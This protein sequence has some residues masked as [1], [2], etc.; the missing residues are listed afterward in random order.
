VRDSQIQ[1]N[2]MSFMRKWQTK[3]SVTVCA[4]MLACSA[5]IVGAEG[6]VPVEG[7]WVATTS[8]GLPVSFEVREGNV[9]NAHFRFNWGFCGTYES[10]L[11]NTDP[12]DSDGHWSF[13]DS[14]GQTIEGTFVTPDRV[15]GTV[16]AAERELPGCPHTRATF[17]AAPGDVP[18]Y[19]KPQVL[20]VQNVNTGHL[21]RR[22][23]EIVLGKHG[24]FSFRGLKWRSFGARRAYAVGRAAI[25]RGKREW[26]PRASLRLSFL[27]EDGPDKRIY[28][29]IRYALHG[30]LPRGYAHHGFRVVG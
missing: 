19:V 1:E 12:I 5:S 23:G 30:P 24:S 6:I 9:L 17:V 2:P 21:S 20:A 10:H 11:P 25:R 29:V 18:P 16:D 26:N 14:R 7:G 28:S 27:V 15:E 13:A 22:P 8:A 4:A 3:V